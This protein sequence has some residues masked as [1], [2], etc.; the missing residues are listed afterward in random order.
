VLVIGWDEGK[1]YREASR[2][3]SEQAVEQEGERNEEWEK[4]MQEHHDYV[5]S[6]RGVKGSKAF[7]A[8]YAVGS[9]IVECKGISEGWD[10]M[11]DLTMN[12]TQASGTV[13]LVADFD[14]GIVEGIMHLGFDPKLLSGPESENDDEC[15]EEHG[16]E[17]EE[18]TFFGR[19][20]K[21]AVQRAKPQAKKP[22]ASSAH[23]RRLYLQWRGQETGEGEI[24]LDY[25][26]KHT[27]Y[28]DFTDA[29]CTAFEGVI[30]IGYIGPNVPFRGFKVSS[31]GGE[32]TKSWTD[33]SDDAHEYARTAR[34]R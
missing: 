22:K 7:Q 9:Y 20:R 32:M 23:P 24:Q 14:F 5:A 34:W 30:Y 21:R 25:N 27:G 31:E 3:D 15:D 1:V 28:L 8:K 16:D 17:D 33:Y 13:A 19:K 26:N 4:K 12:I 11:D 18:P 2:I 29:G 10:N 6:C